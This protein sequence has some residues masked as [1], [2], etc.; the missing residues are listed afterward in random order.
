MTDEL[1][2]S[3]PDHPAPDR[4][5][6]SAEVADGPGGSIGWVL[7]GAL[8]CGVTIGGMLLYVWAAEIDSWDMALSV[9]LG[10]PAVAL[11]GIGAWGGRNWKV[12]EGVGPPLL[13]LA[14]IV[15]MAFFGVLGI[16]V[17]IKDTEAGLAGMVIA[18]MAFFIGVP[19]I[20]LGLVLGMGS[21]LVWK[22]KT[23]QRTGSWL[24]IG[25]TVGVLVSIT[26]SA[27]LA[28]TYIRNRPVAVDNPVG[29][30]HMNSFNA[31]FAALPI[32]P[33]DEQNQERDRI[34]GEVWRIEGIEQLSYSDDTNSWVYT[35]ATIDEIGDPNALTVS[36]KFASAKDEN[37]F[38]PGG[39]MPIACRITGILGPPIST[40]PM[41][42][43][44]AVYEVRIKA[45]SCRII[46]TG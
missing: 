32:F 30:I 38:T 41:F 42:Q 13:F 34:V 24:L 28:I 20:F 8:V 16:G 19:F 15:G 10:V 23:P 3:A 18:I 29:T 12:A 4:Q 1:T 9:I 44:S 6:S 2:E 35:P 31:T 36:L 21:R 11:T 7:A 33:V 37:R 14:G 27:V 46:A 43:E 17:A 5:Q 45:D 40:G 26:L 39:T 22:L 25:V